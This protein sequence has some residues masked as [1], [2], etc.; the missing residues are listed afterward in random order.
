MN[1]IQDN[2][3]YREYG[4]GDF[5][6]RPNKPRNEEHFIEWI[7]LPAGLCDGDKIVGEEFEEEGPNLEIIIEND[8]IFLEDV[9]ANDFSWDKYNLPDDYL[10][11]KLEQEKQ[12]ELEN[13]LPNRI[14]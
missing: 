11:K 7:K 2:H 12:E 4:L 6:Y 1:Q 10:E 9:I 3:V 13:M 14:P 5:V 8:P